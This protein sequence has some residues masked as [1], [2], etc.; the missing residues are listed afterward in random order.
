MSTKVKTEFIRNGLRDL[1]FKD[2]KEGSLLSFRDNEEKINSVTVIFVA[3]NPQMSS[4]LG[5]KRSDPTL[6][7]TIIQDLVRKTIMIVWD[8]KKKRHLIFTDLS[9][10]PFEI[11]EINK[12]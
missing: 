4:V 1:F 9:S 3:D 11:I 8:E 10:D 12:P 6:F 5:K 7:I 2:I